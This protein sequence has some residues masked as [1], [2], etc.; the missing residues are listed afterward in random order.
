MVTIIHNK[1]V[2][3]PAAT[4]QPLQITT[5]N[6][7][8]ATAGTAYSAS[9]AATGGQ[10]P[11]TWSLLS[12]VPNT[13]SWLSVSSGGLLSGTPGTAETETIL[14]Q[15]RD[16]VGTK[17]SS[18]LSLI[19]AAGTSQ[20][21]TFS[22]LV[23]SWIGQNNPNAGL[24]KVDDAGTHNTCVWM[25]DDSGSFLRYNALNPGTCGL[26]YTTATTGLH[27]IC[28][29]YDIRR[30]SSNASKQ[31][32]TY[33]WGQANG[34]GSTSNATFGCTMGG[35]SGNGYGVY[36]GDVATGNNDVS[37]AYAT[38]GYPTGSLPTIGFGSAFSRTPY[39]TQ[40]TTSAYTQ[41]ITG[42]R[43]DTIM[44]YFRASSPTVADGQITIWRNISG[45]WTM[46]MN[47]TNM[48]NCSSTTQDR[49]GFALYEYSPSVGGSFGTW[50]EDYRNVYQMFA[51]PVGMGI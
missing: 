33:G 18:F 8:G 23:T 15:V 38:S 17:S 51:K 49:G 34:V 47:E 12:T 5:A 26:R 16:A 46:I 9:L 13:G 1:W 14:A 36:Y 24:Q 20:A 44:V 37:V 19:V 25:S 40:A 21:W 3:L 2:A 41:D 42:T 29:Q 10:P 28:V 22:D 4:L 30:S 11:Y 27:E 45:V 35:Y 32:K 31:C 48:W 7:P 43:W 50:Y 39:P 6:L